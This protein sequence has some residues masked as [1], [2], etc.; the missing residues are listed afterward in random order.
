MEYY[1]FLATLIV[2]AK[3]AEQINVGNWK[4]ITNKIIYLSYSEGFPVPKVEVESGIS[5]KQVWRRLRNP[6]LTS[7]SREVLFLLLHNK[8]PVKERIFRIRLAI[9]PYCEHCLDLTG[10][11][12]ICDLEHFFCTCQRVLQIWKRLKLMILNL[13]GVEPADLSDWE[14]I[15]LRLP[16]RNANEV[17]WLLGIYLS[18]VW[19]SVFVKG[20]SELCEAQFFGFLRFKYR[21]DQLGAR[22]P[23][24]PIPGLR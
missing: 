3:L 19:G 22:L 9:D 21:T 17:I 23:L 13:L 6:C 2:D 12:I 14:I 24:N 18:E 16:Q 4:I 7:V 15:N 8:L 5:Y 20:S 11:A 10:A 1:D